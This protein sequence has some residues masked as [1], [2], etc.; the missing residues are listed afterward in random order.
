MQLG[1]L[2]RLKLAALPTPLEEAP[3]LSAYLGG[4]RIMFKRDDITGL[5]FGGNEVRK[6]EYLMGEAVDRGCDVV[7]T[8]GAV[9]SNHA[10]VTAAAARRLGLDAVV[11]LS[12]E[13]VPQRQGNLLLD[14]IFGADVR[15]VNTDD[16]FVLMGVVEDVARDLRRQG[17]H[18]YIIPRGGAT[19]L[20]AAG[21]VNAGLELLDQL[22]GRGIRA[23]AVVH[24]TSSGGT[25]AGLYTTMKVTQSGIQVL[26]VSAGPPRDVVT[27]RVRGLVDDLIRLLGLDWRVHPDDIV[28][29]DEYIGERY[30]LPTPACLDAIRLVARTEG[31]LLDP[32]Y[33]GKAMAALID[34]VRRGQFAPDQTVVFWHTGGQ[35]ALFAYAEWLAE[36]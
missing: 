23:D 3:S 20:G 35:P 6:I 28:V 16:E 34:M 12:G 24:A 8:V 2:P 19:A 17:R 25:Q 22:N 33:T 21:F 13:D 15:I 4:P 29:T 31:I 14:A 7:L 32:V 9:Q 1:R 11:V 18:P 5:A 10:R 26:G 27:S 30:G 36:G